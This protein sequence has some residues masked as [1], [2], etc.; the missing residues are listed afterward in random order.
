MDSMI[1]TIKIDDNTKLERVEISENVKELRIQWSENIKEF[2]KSIKLNQVKNLLYKVCQCQRNLRILDLSLLE[3]LVEAYFDIW[4]I[5][6]LYLPK[7]VKRV[8]YRPARSLRKISAL[9]AEEIIVNDAPD[10][11]CVLFGDFLKKINLANTGIEKIKITKNCRFEYSGAFKNCKNLREIDVSKSLDL[12]PYTFENCVNLSTIVLP[13]NIE[14]LEKGVFKGCKNL[15]EIKGGLCITEIEK[16]AFEGC[17]RIEK[18]DLWAIF[19]K[20]DSNKQLEEVKQVFGDG[21]VEHIGIVL[22]E[23]NY[24]WVIWSFSKRRY[25]LTD[26]YSFTENEYINVNDMVYFRTEENPI[27]LVESNVYLFRNSSCL[28]YTSFKVLHAPIESDSFS[29]KE[30]KLILD[31]LK[32]K[33]EVEKEYDELY[34]ELL[35]KVNNI[36]I[37]D[38]V[39]SYSV[40]A[41]TWLQIRPGRDDFEW[42]EY[43]T[44]SLYSDEYVETL[45]PLRNYR[46]YSSGVG[47]ICYNSQDE[48]EALQLQVDHET[49]V[50]KEKALKFYS[51]DKHI[52]F[53]TLKFWNERKRLEEE[54]N[55]IYKIERL[56]EFAIPLRKLYGRKDDIYELLLNSNY[57]DI[58]Q[59]NNIL[60]GPFYRH[61]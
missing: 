29:M 2:N 10:L 57:V 16:D 27:M 25:Y 61:L 17:C 45:L 60:E 55:R 28:K 36:N 43:T 34:K 41:K 53:F 56:K 46:S 42:V 19:K 39:N 1:L 50:Y 3:G 44:T 6:E 13:D 8:N 18:L 59:K 9:G 58:F 15:W 14:K 31:Y 5:Y 38:I 47:P 49:K 21:T 7:T 12:P 37:T 23:F 33:K 4:W 20:M 22:F 30:Q 35:E 11:H 32:P 54:V 26:F 24:K 48:T 40:K 52:A 51:K